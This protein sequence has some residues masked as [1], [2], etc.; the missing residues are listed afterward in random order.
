[1]LEL[2][3]GDCEVTEDF[4]TPCRN[5]FKALAKEDPDK[6][7]RWVSSGLLE[8]CDLTFAAEELGNIDSSL[9]ALIH[10]LSHESAVVREGALMGLYTLS[11]RISDL[12]DH[13]AHNDPSPGVREVAHNCW[14]R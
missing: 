13:H 6:L 1:M 5:S 14:N 10:L 9:P 11:Y 4:P 3:E 2:V 12:F 7:I 8:P